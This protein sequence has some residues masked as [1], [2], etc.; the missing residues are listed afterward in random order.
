MA[1]HVN[2]VQI[3]KNTVYLYLRM[4][5]IMIINLFVVRKTLQILG[6]VD[7]GIYNVIG[8]F[9][10]IFSFLQA[11]LTTAAQRFFSIY[12]AEG[13]KNKLQQSFNLNL[14]TFGM[15]I[16]ALILVSETFGLWFINNNMNIPNERMNAAN[17]VFQF[18]LL[19]LC[20]TMIS[21]PYNAM[22]IAK[23]KMGAFAY[24]GVV[25][26]IL[27]LIVVYLIS[28]VDWDSLQVYAFLVFITNI[29][30]FLLY[31][32]YNNKH[33]KET[34]LKFYWNKKEFLQLFAFSG[35]NFMGTIAFVL[36]SHGINVL[37]N[38]FFDPVVNAARALSYQI[39]N[40]ISRLSG[41][42][43][44]AVKPQIYKSYASADYQDM[45][46]LVLRSTVISVA[47]ISV[48]IFPILANTEFILNV[49]LKEVPQNTVIF[50]QLILLN[51]IIDATDGPAIASILATGKIR[52]FYIVTSSVTLLNIPISYILLSLGAH[53]AITV[54]VSITLSIIVVFIRAYFIKC[55]INI[56]LSD[57][58]F[59][60]IR[61]IVACALIT[62]LILSVF[63]NKA[64]DILS[65]ILYSLLIAFVVIL[66]FTLLVADFKDVKIVA[67]MIHKKIKR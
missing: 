37:L 43:I 1:S 21:V 44:T 60:I 17:V 63:Y 24:I 15:I 31:Y 7:Y 3:A 33:F 54:I 4:I 20:I 64:N 8:G 2:N 22:I 25:E 23:E 5:I 42:F 11:T 53:P 27:K 32:F 61:I 39:Y 30:V 41:N 14:L 57:Y 66:V 50:T 46:K 51:G 67:N 16:V 49:W 45:H 28:V 9:V 19:T 29:I 10:L 55:L 13:D 36:R 6:E 52:K 65:F 56:N 47:L 18:S 35:W 58:Y 38:I 59:L 34:K 26:A 48:I 40:A 62:G 12:I